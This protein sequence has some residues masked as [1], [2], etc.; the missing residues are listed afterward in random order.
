MTDTNLYGF[1][2]GR[3][4]ADRDQPFLE[5][6]DGAVV[7]Y[8]AL[9]AQVARYALL[10]ESLGARPGDR[11]AA[12]VDKCPEALF[13]YLACVRAG[14]IYLPLN[15][16]YEAAELAYFIG[17]AE[18]RLFVCAP[19]RED[20]LRD[21][22]A[23]GVMV[24]TLG[25]GGPAGP[26]GSLPTAAAAMDGTHATV[27][28]AADDVAAILYTSGT[29]GRPKGAMLTHGNLAS[30]AA[31]L[32]RI[33]GFRGDDVLIHALP[34]YHVH[35]LFVAVHCV[36]SSGSRM[37]FLPKFDASAVVEG[38]PSA[39]VLMGV[40]TF[41]T[42]LL[43]EPALTPAQCARMR[44]FIAGSA[45]LLAETFAEF[46]ART[47][48]TILERYGMSEAGMIASN[49]LDGDRV[50]GTVGQALPDVAVRVAADDGTALP[51]GAV[52]TLEIKGPNLFKGYWRQPD[53]TR[54]EF[55][56]DGFFIT[57]DMARMA[58]DGRISIIGR[59]KD[60]IITGG[61]NV[62]PKEVEAA[63]DAIDGV[64]ESAV[65]GLPD[66]DF[67]EMVV[68]VVK[69]RNAAHGLDADAIRA[70]LDGQLA[71]FKRPKQVHFV[72]ELPRNAMGKVQKNLLRERFAA[73][74][75]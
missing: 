56:D 30:N 16:A 73:G 24:R 17:D 6:P 37:Q 25:P 59:A 51:A 48:Q 52:G 41:Y 45:P 32:V 71:K 67:G 57:G 68:A 58:A 54:A 1:L 39:T 10:L 46:Q 74:T 31:T 38:L 22:A 75:S 27:P 35:G 64:A 34:I 26:C 14:L 72:D 61:L 18:P 12:Q 44:L 3:F 8:S 69:R 21:L 53:K 36:L 5:T 42:R 7:R 4:P 50:A 65:I 60:L 13:L 23:G 49:P 20:A 15:T 29:T 2:R 63:I 66:A 47:G 28:V 43:A 55:R 9:D 40:P 70:A 11:V 33:W 19:A 62:Y